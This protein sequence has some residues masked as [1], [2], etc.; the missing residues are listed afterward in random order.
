MKSQNQKTIGAFGKAKILRTKEQLK[1]KSYKMKI[2]V[3]KEKKENFTSKLKN[4]IKGGI[5]NVFRRK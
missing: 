2:I 3:K 4:F 5:K 1:R